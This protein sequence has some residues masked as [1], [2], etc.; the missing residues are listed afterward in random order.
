[1]VIWTLWLLVWV[2]AL[3]LALAASVRVRS[4]VRAHVDRRPVIDDQALESILRTGVL[5]TDE[6][7]PLDLDQVREEERRFWEE[8]EWESWDETE[9]AEEW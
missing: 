8:Q 4:R 5:V 1:M 2:A 7:P 3:V 9:E 6:D